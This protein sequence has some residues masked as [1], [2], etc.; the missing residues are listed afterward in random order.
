[1]NAV[2]GATLTLTL[3]PTE[4]LFG[5]RSTSADIVRACRIRYRVWYLS[6]ILKVELPVPKKGGKPIANC[7]WHFD[8]VSFFSQVLYASQS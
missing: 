3:S 4:S 1:M 7:N 6:K 8:R 2:F 5:A